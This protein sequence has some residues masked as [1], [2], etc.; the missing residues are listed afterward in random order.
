MFVDDIEAA[1]VDHA[2]L[3]NATLQRR[4]HF[5]TMQ[6]GELAIAFHPA[7]EKSKAGSAVPYFVTEDL[8]Q[9]IA[10][11]ADE[12]FTI[13]RGP[14]TMNGELIAQLRNAKDT[15]IGYVQKL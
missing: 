9:T 15:R 7:D 8:S 10:E 5:I 13:Y 4:E 3:L 2:K 6:V 14:I 1:A 12:G 11:A